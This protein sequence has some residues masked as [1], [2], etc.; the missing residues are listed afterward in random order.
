MIG[1]NRYSDLSVFSFHPVKNITTAE[2]SAITTNNID[3]HKKL[4]LLRENGQDFNK[5]NKLKFPTKYNITLLGYNFRINEINSSLGISQ[6]KKTNKFIN[7]KKIIAKKYFKELILPE[8]N[9]PNKD[10]L[11]QSALHLFIIKINFKMLNINKY[12]LINKLKKKKIILIVII[13]L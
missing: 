1:S 13:F 7:Q 11:S 12:E 8:I 2:G 4:L 5:I 3:I 10:I 9:L 6:I